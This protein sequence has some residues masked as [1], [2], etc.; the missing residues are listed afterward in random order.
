MLGAA[1]SSAA[2]TVRPGADGGGQRWRR[3]ALAWSCFGFL[4]G[5]LFWSATGHGPALTGAVPGLAPNQTGSLAAAASAKPSDRLPA[6]SHGQTAAVRANCV[7][8]VL[9]RI[10]QQTRRD[11]C[12][13]G[14]PELQ[15]AESSGRQDRL[16]PLE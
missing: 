2:G 4:A 10:T 6:F 5:T 15:F 3:S 11:P 14:G 9:D 12:P 7:A 8:L 1:G 16:P 13:P